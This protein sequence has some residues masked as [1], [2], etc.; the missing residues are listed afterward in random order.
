MEEILNIGARNED[1]AAIFNP[2][3]E[4]TVRSLVEV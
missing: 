4:R 1:A 3:A 2:S